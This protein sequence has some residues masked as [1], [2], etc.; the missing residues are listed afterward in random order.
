MKTKFTVRD[1]LWI[2]LSLGLATVPTGCLSP[3]TD[4]M[5]YVYDEM[6]FAEQKQEIQLVTTG[7]SIPNR[8]VAN[9]Y[10][11]DV[12]GEVHQLRTLSYE[13]AATWVAGEFAKE[14]N[15]LRLKRHNDK[16]GDLCITG[17]GFFRFRDGFIVETSIARGSPLKIGKT[18]DGPFLS[19]PINR[20]QMESAFGTDYRIERVKRKNLMSNP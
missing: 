10:L 13:T 14:Q 1:L 7:D 5:Y 6:T 4:E 8:P 2:V 16:G 12:S 11:Q 19:F 15:E 18:P 17:P 20:S 9:L 3:Y